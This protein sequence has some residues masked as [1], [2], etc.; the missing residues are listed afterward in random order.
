LAAIRIY[1]R[2]RELLDVNASSPTNG[3]VLSYDLAT[4]KWVPATVAGGAGSQTLAETLALGNDANGLEIVNAADPT[5]D[6]A[7][8]T[9]ASAQ[10][11]ADAAQAAAEAASDPAGS[12]AT[13]QAAAEAASQPLDADLTA[14]AALDSSAAGAIASDGAGWVKKTYAQMRTALGLGTLATQNGTFSGTS[15]GTNT[16]DQT[17]VSG[18]AGTATALQTGRAIDGQTFDGTA[19]ITVIAPGTHAATSKATPVDADEVPLV[20]SAAS[21]VLK[22]V[23]WA[24]VKATLKTYFD[25]LY[26]ASGTVRPATGCLVRRTTNQAIAN[27]INVDVA[28]TVEDAATSGTHS[29]SVNPERLI[30]PVAGW[31]H[32]FASVRWGTNGTL[33]R[34]LGLRKNGSSAVADQI[35]SE[36]VA[37]VSSESSQAISGVVK[38]A[39]GEYVTAF[40]FQNSGGSLNI[41]VSVQQPTAGLVLLGT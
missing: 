23:T 36:L 29:T 41:D 24:N 17:S 13:A 11:Q 22:K 4:S 20:D 15:S 38:L 37:P 33:V 12:A 35:A 14:I 28:W 40:V 2:L 30:A 9:N 39:A 3:Q 26:Q 32:V 25:T 16:G 31:Y 8:A 21:N 7:V 10:A 27:A 6:Q 1:K 18:N 5:T 19:A 34:F